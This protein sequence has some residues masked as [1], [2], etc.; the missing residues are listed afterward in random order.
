MK[1]TIGENDH[2]VL[3]AHFVIRKVKIKIYKNS[4]R[5]YRNFRNGT[6]IINST[7]IRQSKKNATG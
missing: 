4:T 3:T 1:E 5:L 2:S 6:L 7:N